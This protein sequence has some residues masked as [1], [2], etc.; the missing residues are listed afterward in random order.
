[1][2]Y[3]TILTCTAI[4]AAMTVPASA[5]TPA[6]AKAPI[7]PP[8]ATPVMTG[9]LTLGYDTQYVF[10]GYEVL[11]ANGDKAEHLLWGALDLNFGLAENLSLNMNAWYGHSAGA[12]YS[13]VDLYTRLSY[14]FGPFTAG[15]SFKYYSYPKY[16]S[17]TD[18]QLEPGIEATI[19]A[20]PNTSIYLGAFYELEAEQWYYELG[21]SYTAK[22]NDTF[23]LI[24]GAT[25]SYINVNSVDFALNENDAHH[26]AVYLKAPIALSKTVTLT[27]YIAA[28]FPIGEQV[29]TFQDDLIYGGANI[30]FSF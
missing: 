18:S 27:P 9:S 7:S 5:G 30:S 24:P 15:P 11:A 28:N 8:P 29:K 14:N 26:V 21:V 6:P 19:T 23:S 1:M 25:F 4:A 22:I 13:E 20:I 16:G 17:A 10:R 3:K 2:N 12:N